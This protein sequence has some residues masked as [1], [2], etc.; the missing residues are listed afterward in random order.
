ML[1]YLQFFPEQFVFTLYKN[2]I[3]MMTINKEYV[4]PQIPEREASLFIKKARELC[5]WDLN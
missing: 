4:I 2:H 1:K 5:L 3:T